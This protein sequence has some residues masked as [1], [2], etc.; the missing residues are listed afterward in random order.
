M[1]MTFL[2][3]FYGKYMPCFKNIG[4]IFSCLLLTACANEV[5][6]L[7][8][9]HRLPEGTFSLQLTARLVTCPPGSPVAWRH[10]AVTAPN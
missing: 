7:Y 2:G 9:G 5:E 8:T 3:C 6:T 4:R 10:G 1:D